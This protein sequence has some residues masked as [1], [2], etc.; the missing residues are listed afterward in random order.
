V[1]IARADPRRRARLAGVL[2]A[3]ALACAVSAPAQP[4][5]PATPKYL[6]F[7]DFTKD[8][9]AS[10]VALKR[11]YNDAI[12]RYNDALYEYHV[13]LE[14]H[15]RLVEAYNRS[16]DS[17]EKKRARQDAEAL[18]GR[19]AAL[20]RDALTRAAAVDEAARKAAAGGVVITR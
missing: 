1:K 5:Q 6:P 14:K 18:R 12:Q 10:T 11:A 13:T 16:G 17:A 8:E 15:D 20:R 7:A 2:L 9:T 4:A 3:V 19:L